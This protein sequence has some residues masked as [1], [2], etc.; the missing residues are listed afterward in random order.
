MMVGFHA[1]DNDDDENDDSSGS[2]GQGD[3]DGINDN[4][5]GVP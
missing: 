2:C 4:D 5:K 1:D 3:V